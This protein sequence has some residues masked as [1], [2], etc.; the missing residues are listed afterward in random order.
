MHTC[1]HCEKPGI[2]FVAKMLSNPLF[3][4]VCR[5]CGGYASKC[6]GVLKIQLAIAIAF[7]ATV[8][9]LTSGDT[10]KVLGA[11]TAVVIIVIG[12]AG[13]LCRRL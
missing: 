1:P 7:L 12:Q 13:P 11:L 4:A 2:G 8:P 6:A 9:N 10:A 3:P 5:L